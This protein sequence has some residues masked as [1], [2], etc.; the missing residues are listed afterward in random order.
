MYKNFF[1]ATFPEG[2]KQWAKGWKSSK[3][4]NPIQSALTS[5]ELW[6]QQVTKC[7]DRRLTWMLAGYVYIY[8]YWGIWMSPILLLLLLR[9]NHPQKIHSRTLTWNLK[10]TQWKTKLL[11]KPFILKFHVRFCRHVRVRRV[12]HRRKPPVPNSNNEY[13]IQETT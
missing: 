3:Q 9:Y 13:H 2:P 10:M 6:S 1:D 8:I 11:Y 5:R 4:R 12:H 7:L